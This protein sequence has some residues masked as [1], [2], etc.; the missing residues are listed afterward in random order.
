MGKWGYLLG[1]SV[2]LVLL[3]GLYVLYNVGMRATPCLPPDSLACGENVGYA[4]VLFLAMFAVTF[5]LGVLAQV[6]LWFVL[7]QRDRALLAAR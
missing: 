3:V 4:L 7:R 1:W 5:V 6:I 2:P